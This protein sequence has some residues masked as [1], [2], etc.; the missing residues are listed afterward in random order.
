MF[1]ALKNV[2]GL[3]IMVFGG[4]IRVLQEVRKTSI[5]NQGGVL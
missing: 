2:F 4:S 3:L 5:R 1:E